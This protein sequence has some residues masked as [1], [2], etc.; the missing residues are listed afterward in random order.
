MRPS[1][2]DQSSQFDLGGLLWLCCLLQLTAEE[3]AEETI[4]QERK[5]QEE[6]QEKSQKQTQLRK[7]ADCV[8]VAIQHVCHRPVARSALLGAHMCPCPAD[9]AAMAPGAHRRDN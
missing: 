5:L 7:I 2:Y 3:I 9:R 6:G 4:K 8:T 1:R